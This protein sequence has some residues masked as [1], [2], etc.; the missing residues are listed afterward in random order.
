MNPTENLE[1]PRWRDELRK[2]FDGLVHRHRGQV[3]SVIHRLVRDPERAEELTQDALLTAFARL[4]TYEGRSGFGTWLC[5]IGKM[6]ALND[7]RHSRELLTD[8]GVLEAED[9]G[10]TAL[11]GLGRAEREELIRQAA[12][13]LLDPTE[14]EVVYLR[15][16]E[17]LPRGAIAGILELADENAVRVL[18]QRSRRRLERGIRVRLEQ[19][20]H[21]TSFL[22]TSW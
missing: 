2:Q 9:A 18:L 20:G 7:I 3:Y 15:Y 1:D 22:R 13:D 11:R 19:L 17:Q 21:G 6:L 14:Q 10:L 12:L 5:G 16:V 4:D 8:D